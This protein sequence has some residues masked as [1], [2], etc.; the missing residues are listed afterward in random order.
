M[1]LKKTILLVFLSFLFIRT[2]SQDGNLQYYQNGF[3]IKQYSE[4]AGLTHNYPRDIFEDSRGFLWIA[5]PQGL[6]R[7]D[8]RQFTNY[9]IKEGLPGA[10][11]T[12]ISEDSLGFIYV[13]TTAGIA[14][15]TGRTGANETCFYTYP[16]TTS[17]S[18][19][20]V[21]M[22]AIDSVSLIFQLANSAIFQLRKDTLRQLTRPG[23]GMMPFMLRDRHHYSYACIGD[24]LR[25]FDTDFRNSNNILLPNSDYSAASRDNAN[26]LH[27]YYKGKK[28]RLDKNGIAN[29]SQVPDSIIWF[30]SIDSLDKMVYH[31]EGG[32]FL[33]DNYRS[34]KI[35]DLDTL[36]RS[37]SGFCRAKD[38]SV[39][40]K[41]A[42]LGIF[43]M[44]PLLYSTEQIT[45]NRNYSRI[46]NN[47]RIIE[48]DYRLAKMPGLAE[49]YNKLQKTITSVF[50]SK[51]DT[52]WFCT[53]HGVYKQYPGTKAEYYLFPGNKEVWSK[54][55]NTISNAVESENGDIWFYG[56]AGAI[57]YS[58]GHFK[59]Y[60]SRHG[61]GQF[62]RAKWLVTDKDN[63]VLLTDHYN[64]LF[65]IRDDTLLSVARQLNMPGFASDKITTDTSGFVWVEYKKK[66]FRIGKKAGNYSIIDSIVPFAT[67][68]LPEIA[69]FAFDGQNN[70]WVGY[71]GGKIQVY[72][73]AE[74]GHYDYANSITYTTDDGLDAIAPF[75]YNLWPDSAGNIVL[76]PLDQKSSK[77]FRFK[78]T[79]ALERK[80][81]NTPRVSFTGILINHKDP[82]WVSRGYVTNQEGMPPSP[83]LSYNNNDITFKYIG[84][85]L[86]NPTGI[87][88]QVKLEGYDKEWQT[89]AET[90]TNYTN[91][92]PGDY[93]FMVKVAN[94]NGVW[95]QP[96]SWHFSIR[97]PWY[98][99]WWATILFILAGIALIT[100]IFYLRLNTIRQNY[101]VKNLKLASQLKSK[102]IALMGHDVMTPLRYIAKVSLQLKTHI[103]TLSK[104]TVSETLGDINATANQLH[105]FGECVIHW[106]K[107]QNGTIKP[108]VEDLD[109]VPLVNELIE[110]HLPLTIEKRNQIVNE[111]PD[112]LYCLQ[113]PTVIKIIL[114]N[115]LLNANK[116]TLDG[117]IR[118]LATK[119]HGLL[120]LTI[121]DN[122]RGMD[123]QKVDAL[124]DL[125]P[126]T[127]S[128]GT[129][130]EKGWG[131]GYMVMIDL[132][133]VSKG[134]LNVESKLNEGTI[135]TISLPQLDI[136]PADEE[137]D[138]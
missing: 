103:Q 130:M 24:S 135:V 43:R 138:N 68:A 100:G 22:Q 62:G 59:H 10:Y 72:F 93:R 123:Q 76:T 58:K 108:I 3:Y 90:F 129:H 38:G 14:R 104:Q 83:R 73:A 53:N 89:T 75:R 17:F 41:I 42:G 4:M 21:G 86:S 79:D 84:I 57:R 37:C 124:N 99:T 44:V 50:L 80:K 101:Q 92:P 65:E 85:S 47:R 15:Y 112:Q 5:T 23:N 16:K 36:S 118:V 126:I 127:S 28:N 111:L 132:L 34:T 54:S 128:Q 113:D 77:I 12:Q 134:K 88:Y 97:P 45:I 63:T 46:R 115:L 30:C 131:M 109:L 31:K 35:M 107:L 18:M 71:T 125:R 2:L 119:Q 67:F 136:H 6:S 25:V 55:A 122:G 52:V 33:Y 26:N 81:L 70:C 49:T 114:H 8:G 82:D 106:I 20:V 56:Y 1:R 102:L 116:F 19:S 69:A 98:R 96:V 66:L 74:N 133:L 7:F 61:L 105:F 110:L 121:S 87:V 51:T 64:T 120:T 40:I 137:N 39:W 48:T 91:L 60:T 95:G 32:I 94:V 117:K 78:I 13:A 27:I 9:G 11:I 29:S